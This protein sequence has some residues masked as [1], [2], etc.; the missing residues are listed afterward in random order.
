MVTVVC[1]ANICRSPMGEVILQKQLN[2]AGLNVRVNSAGVDAMVGRQPASN[3][4]A[5]LQSAG[6]ALP[7]GK[8]AQ[9]L[10]APMAQMTSLILVMENLHK[11]WIVKNFPQ[12][13]GKVW[14]LGHWLGKEIDDPI[15]K[16]Q[17]AFDACLSE[18]EEALHL[19]VP[20]IKA[21]L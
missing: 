1:T 19:W 12:S 2:D 5:A 18:L 13:S 9:Q 14:L 7:Q 16:P 20:K 6:Y 11:Q 8:R 15:G 21:L 3:S 10:L 17:P 4:L